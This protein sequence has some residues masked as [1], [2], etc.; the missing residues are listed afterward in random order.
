MGMLRRGESAD[1]ISG[2]MQVSRM[3]VARKKVRVVTPRY[4]ARER[5]TALVLVVLLASLA[6][7]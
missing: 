5:P 6:E 3:I 2:W 7:T 4:P 1:F